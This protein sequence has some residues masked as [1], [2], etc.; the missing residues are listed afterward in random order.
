MKC[1]V[2]IA[3]PLQGSL[4]QALAQVAIEALPAA[5][6]QVTVENLCDEVFF[7]KLTVAERQSYYLPSFDS[8]AVG[9]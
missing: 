6:H 9:E 1:L 7:P 2:V 8:F 5:G 4:C 3:H